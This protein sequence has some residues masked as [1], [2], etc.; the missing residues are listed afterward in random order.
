MAKG[1]YQ[2]LSRLESTLDELAIE[3]QV[4]QEELQA[5]KISVAEAR[6]KM[7]RFAHEVEKLAR[8]GGCHLRVLRGEPERAPV[9]GALAA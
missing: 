3:A 4:A 1:G 9:R 2:R 6:L 5:D 7:Y 8:E